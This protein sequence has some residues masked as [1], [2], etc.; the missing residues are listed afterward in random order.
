MT[1]NTR[2]VLDLRDPILNNHLKLRKLDALARLLSP[3]AN[4]T[5]CIALT[6]FQGKFL[7]SSNGVKDEG[8]SL[9]LSLFVASRLKIIRE[10]ITRNLSKNILKATIEPAEHTFLISNHDTLTQEL[11]QRIF[12]SAFLSDCNKLIM[13]LRDCGGNFLKDDN[14]MIANIF[15][16]LSLKPM[17]KGNAA[18]TEAPDDFFSMEE[19]DLIFGQKPVTILIP[20][21]K[22]EASSPKAKT[23]EWKYYAKTYF[24]C[25]GIRSNEFSLGSEF[26]LKTS[27]VDFHAEQ[28]ILHYALE[29]HDPKNMDHRLFI[30]LT[31][32]CCETCTTVLAE[33]QQKKGDQLQ[34]MTRGSS[35]AP[36]KGVVQLFCMEPLPVSE[37]LIHNP[38]FNRLKHIHQIHSASD[39]PKPQAASLFTENAEL[40]KKLDVFLTDAGVRDIIT[41]FNPALEC[42]SD[43]ELSPKKGPNHQDAAAKYD[44]PEQSTD[45]SELEKLSSI[46]QRIKAQMKGLQYDQALTPL[47]VPF[48]KISDGISKGQSLKE[49]SFSELSKKLLGDNPLL[50]RLKQIYLMRHPKENS[51]RK[52]QATAL[53]PTNTQLLKKLDSFLKD[54]GAQE[55]IDTL[56]A[57][58]GFSSDGEPSH[59][60]ALNPKDS[61]T[62]S[63][64]PE[65]STDESE[66]EKISLIPKKILTKMRALQATK[67]FDRALTPLLVPFISICSEMSTGQRPMFPSEPPSSPP[68]SPRFFSVHTS[69]T[70][71][72]WH[73]GT[74][75][76]SDSPAPSAWGSATEGDSDSSAL[77]RTSPIEKLLLLIS[78]S[79]RSE[80]YPG[81]DNPSSLLKLT[82]NHYNIISRSVNAGRPACSPSPT[83]SDCTTRSA[84]SASPMQF[85]PS[86]RDFTENTC[87]SPPRQFFMSTK[88]LVAP[89]IVQPVPIKPDQSPLTL[90]VT[91]ERNLAPSGAP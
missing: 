42:S 33:F 44:S 59:N 83:P 81:Q 71:E 47:L 87:I 17:T 13:S 26:S 2:E 15:K 48:I 24:D 75:V 68:C 11:L 78:F 9:L 28:L 60:G 45:E 82:T 79:Q 74:E 8:S 51:S 21:E 80:L 72:E 30:G 35:N 43:G 12:Q 40:L 56:D 31:K 16:V 64:S 65:Q 1:T 55:M 39:S 91:T 32:L 52:F 53:S 20:K 86:H 90:T 70:P 69:P 77:S 46:P 61:A 29:T 88:Q 3:H 76:D 36:F 49:E 23:K 84:R 14:E 66:L 63:P 73:A 18:S 38:Q 6:V 5:A 25:A 41:A 85:W 4:Y 57:G 58:L 34:I 54:A 67:Q 37:L 27:A 22:A 10:F 7:I 62:K 19:S 50:N 89:K